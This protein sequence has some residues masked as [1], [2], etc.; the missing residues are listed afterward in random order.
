MAQ[1]I[2]KPVLAARERLDVRRN[3]GKARSTPALNF[4]LRV[5][6]RLA[7]VATLVL[8]VGVSALMLVR[9]MY[10]DKVMPSVYVADVPV[11]GLSRA[12]AQAA[13]DQRAQELLTSTL[14]F[15][16]EGRQWTTTLASMGVQADTTGSVDAAYMIGR[17]QDA[18]DRIGMTID[19]ARADAVLPLR[20]AIDPATLDTWI[21]TVTTD[22]G[23]QP[24]NAEIIIS[25]SAQVEIREDVDG[26]VVDRAR[27]MAIIED[28]ISSLT[29]YRGPLPVTFRAANIHVEDVRPEFETLSAALSKPITIIYKN[30]DWT[31]QPEDLVPFIVQTA[32][33]DRPGYAVTIDDSGLGKWL[34]AMV[35]D[36]IDRE[37]INA[38]IAWDYEKDRVKAVSESAKGVKVLAGPLADAVIAS[39]NGDHS[40]V[41]IPVRGIAPEID[42]QRLDDLGITTKLGVGTSSFYGSGY[43]RRTNIEVGTSYLNG[44]IVRPGAEFTFNGSVGDITAEA[45][46]VEAA[47]VD[48]ERIGKDV[49]GGICQ[50][51]TTVF[52]AAFF[53]G[54]PI[55][56]WWPHLYRLNF[57][58]LDGWPAGLDASILQSGPRETW[59]DFKFKN[60]T[61]SYLLVEAYVDGET[62]VVVIYGAETNWDVFVSDP[63]EGE[64]LKG[65]DQDDVEIVDPE[66][67]A[68]TINHTELMQDGL[69]ISY[70][71]I[72][73][74][75]TGEVISD[76]I[77][78]SKFEARGNVY[79]VSPDMKGESP[80]QTASE[81]KKGG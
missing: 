56:E 34:L 7:L 45:G 52:R 14:V 72:V 66:L 62:D 22:V 5:A 71:R 1:A 17:E 32:R 16:Y 35:G 13:V 18:R 26:L 74:D 37:P 3:A 53:A 78:Y 33:T 79:K 75:S 25:S 2:Q 77:F 30:K 63:W 54:F 4:F 65:I 61:D 55:T 11:G 24:R 59:G 42:D 38:S 43:E 48:G 50:V 28:A 41:E 57:Y 20:M 23:V 47:V 44:T 12:E 80:A 21:D 27:V 49:G 10:G 39:F 15:D 76:R 40:D 19:L 68:G 36:R 67:P 81:R 69:E 64:P 60:I 6:H 51:S 31:L 73:K 70:Q 58:E 29:P 9:T 46:Y 8:L